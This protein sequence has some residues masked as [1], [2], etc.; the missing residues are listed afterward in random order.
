[1]SL[2]CAC[3]NCDL[4]AG[5]GRVVK[6]SW[7]ISDREYFVETCRCPACRGRGIETLCETCREEDIDA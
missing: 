7:S 5:S 6:C 3:E 1:M 4:C 2:L